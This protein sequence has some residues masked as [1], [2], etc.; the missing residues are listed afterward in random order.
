[1]ELE[2]EPYH[3]VKTSLWNGQGKSVTG[4]GALACD[5]ATALL[6]LAWTCA[7]AAAGARPAEHA[8]HAGYREFG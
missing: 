3:V 1:M 4:A 8:D 7:A 5:D 2:H 6:A